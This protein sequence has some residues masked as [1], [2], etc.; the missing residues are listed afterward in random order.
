[1][2]VRTTETASKSLS[3]KRTTIA[4]ARVE[5]A[6]RA[7]TCASASH[8][9]IWA[10]FRR[11]RCR[12]GI[13]IRMEQLRALLASG[14]VLVACSSTSSGSAP[15][16][17]AASACTPGQSVACTGAGSCSGGQVCNAAGSG[18]GACECG[19]RDAGGSDGASAGDAS[20]AGGDAND[21][22]LAW[23]PSALGGALSLWL[24]A[25][26][27]VTATG[28]TISKWADQSSQHNDA[29]PSGAGALTPPTTGTLGAHAVVQFVTTNA[30]LTIADVASLQ[31]PDDFAVEIVASS[32]TT[33]G[34]LYSK[35]GGPS[36]PDGMEMHLQSAPMLFINN[37]YVLNDSL[38]GGASVNLDGKLHVLGVRRTGAGCEAR[39]D[40]T[41]TAGASSACTTVLKSWPSMPVTIGRSY[42]HGVGS[43]EQIAEIVSVKGTVAD[44]DITKLEAYFK[45]KY[46]L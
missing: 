10:V 11:A 19:V 16:A 23:Q 44:A 22:S 33:G 12:Y 32:A 7:R 6:A 17:S 9:R 38:Q 3:S 46:G 34:F 27:G 30:A 45:A 31:F 4:A 36:G 20:D 41:A 29:T 43:D 40:G 24:E 2:Y 25:D 35:V 1:M 39:V 37:P 18:Y 13:S 21:G 26:V 42:D 8:G 5:D 14:F 15:D 28:Q